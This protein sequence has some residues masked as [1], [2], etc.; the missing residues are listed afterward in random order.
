VSKRNPHVGSAVRE[1]VAEMR[2]KDP[3]F[4]LA[5]DKVRLAKRLR[6]LREARGINQ[7]DLARA[8]K[9][10]Q[11][12][13]ARFESGDHVPSLELIQRVAHALGVR[14]RVELEET[15]PRRFSA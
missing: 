10:T 3:A 11:S 4:A 14:V 15:A 7:A 8:V 9:T 13:I 5:L 1:H 12:S 2:K 6:R